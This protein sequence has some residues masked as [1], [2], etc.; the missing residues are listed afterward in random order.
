MQAFTVEDVQHAL[1]TFGFGITIKHYEQSTATSQLAAD[2]IGCQLGQIAKSICFL[3]EDAP[4]LAV[5]SGDQL[6]DDRK[7][8]AFIGVRS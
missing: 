8:A 5:M 4:V 1:D 3:V 6:V 7:I 2:V